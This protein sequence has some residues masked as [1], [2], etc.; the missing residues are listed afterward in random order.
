MNS[1]VTFNIELA[2]IE[3]GSAARA[4][5]V[6]EFKADVATAMGRDFTAADVVVNSIGS[7]SVVVD[8]SITVLGSQVA[9][10]FLQKHILC[11]GHN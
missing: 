7:G 10:V 3:F 5:F 9:L 6:E 8:F 4:Q 2:S 1:A 11:A